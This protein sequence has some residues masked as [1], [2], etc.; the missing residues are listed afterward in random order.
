V[1]SCVQIE[2]KVGERP[3]Q[4]RTQRPIHRK[5]RAGNLRG[6]LQIEN[7]EMFAKFPVRLS[8]EVKLRR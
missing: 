7:S 1:L 4:S 6:P 8:F 5:S 3:L 2:H